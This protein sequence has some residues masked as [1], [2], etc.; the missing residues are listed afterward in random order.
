VTLTA[1]EEAEERAVLLRY[2]FLLLMR[3]GSE[4]RLPV[5]TL[6]LAL[7]YKW[8]D[9]ESKT[10]I[11]CM[12]PSTASIS[13][14]SLPLPVP[15]PRNTILSVKQRKNKIQQGHLC[16]HQALGRFWQ[17]LTLSHQRK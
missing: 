14:I 7:G 4:G 8:R 5:L 16:L 3:G 9:G 1:G 11:R 6:D 15:L 2:K 17:G 13:N 10:K 12:F